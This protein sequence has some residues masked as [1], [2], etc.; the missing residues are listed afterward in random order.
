LK[1]TVLVFVGAYLPGYK[2]GGPVRSIANLVEVLGGEIDFRIVT[3]DRDEKDRVPYPGIQEGVWTPVGKAKVLYLSPKSLGFTS[4]YRLLA[5]EKADCLYLNSFF[6]RPFSILPMLARAMGARGQRQL[7][8][9]PRG[10]FAPGALQL[11]PV[12]KRL[13]I[14]IARRM[15]VYREALFQ[16]SSPFE[17]AD[18]RNGL[19]DGTNIRQVQVVVASDLPVS[20]AQTYPPGPAEVPFKEPGKLRVVFLSRLSPMKNL[21]GAIRILRKVSGSIEFNIY[22]PAE[23]RDYWGQC[24]REL[25]DLPAHIQVGIHPQVEHAR[26]REVLASHHLLLLPTLGEN[27]GH[28]IYEALAAGVPVLISDRTPWRGL[29]A[30]G[31]GWDLPLDRE[32]LFRAALDQCVAMDNEQFLLAS[33]C[34]TAMARRF[35]ADNRVIAANRALFLSSICENTGGALQ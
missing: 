20:D 16:A 23:D 33:Q 15:A 17:A 22:G 32:D 34:A 4:I 19:G 14:G 31:A 29:A 11:R 6:G 13:W 21:L 3:L 35:A 24:E 5:S 28:V 8:L 27:F 9:A 12:R 10:E 30:D 25:K 7:M 1:P 2:A 26:V 18:I